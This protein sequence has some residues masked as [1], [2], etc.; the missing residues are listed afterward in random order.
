[1]LSSSLQH[2]IFGLYLALLLLLQSIGKY[3][4]LIWFVVTCF[5]LLGVFYLE[6]ENQ[7]KKKKIKSW[8]KATSFQTHPLI[9]IRVNKSTVGVKMIFVPVY[10]L[11]SI[12]FKLNIVSEYLNMWSFITAKE[13]ESFNIGQWLNQAKCKMTCFLVCLTLFVNWVC[14]LSVV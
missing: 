13:L 7:I 6:K 5:G 14:C 10:M 3:N 2:S 4:F 9:Q 8:E 11:A 1:M 12:W